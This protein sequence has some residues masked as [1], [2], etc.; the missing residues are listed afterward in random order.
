MQETLLHFRGERYRLFAWVV[1]NDHVHVLFQP[2]G[3]FT[4][5]QIMHSW[6]SFTANQ[7][8]RHFGRHGV[9]SIWQSEGHDHIIRNEQDL[10]E[11]WQYILDNPLK[12]WP[13][14]KDYK[15]VSK[16]T[17]ADSFG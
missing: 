8:Q 16:P 2:L 12:R 14:G 13:D 9:G 7:F 1:M 5:S 15:W 10:Y 4:R 3:D 6:K 11:K 17:D